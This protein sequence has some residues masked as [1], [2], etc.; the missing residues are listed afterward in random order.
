MTNNS[1]INVT[2]YS[3]SN[4]EKHN[5]NFGIC[6]N[7]QPNQD[8]LQ[9]E[10]AVKTKVIDF[11]PH[12]ITLSEFKNIFYSNEFGIY[13][14]NELYKDSE[15]I[16]FGKQKLVDGD[17]IREIQNIAEYIISTYEEHLM[18]S[19]QNINSF[20]L[21]KLNKE[22]LQYKSL[23]DVCNINVFHTYKDLEMII[24]NYRMINGKK[25]LTFKFI[26][27]NELFNDI[28]IVFNFNYDV[29]FS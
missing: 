10:T 28:E 1:F 2:N 3:L 9:T 26:Y 5:I 7:I 29:D 16:N 17:S 11:H 14:I 13:C 27:K 22:L 23:C 19:R 15:F 18:V 25:R 8:L 20:I 21:M 24:N 12:D 6:H 4:V